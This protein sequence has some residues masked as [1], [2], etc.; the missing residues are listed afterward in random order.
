MTH[1]GEVGLR[2][3]EEG[4]AEAGRILEDICKRLGITDE[5]GS[6]PMEATP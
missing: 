1:E 6:E 2:T 3:V 4:A 5:C